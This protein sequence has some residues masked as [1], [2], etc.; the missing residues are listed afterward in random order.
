MA[1]KVIV[2][3]AS[4]NRLIR[5]HLPGWV[6]GE[7]ARGVAQPCPVLPCFVTVPFEHP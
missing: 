1:R 2:G 7:G 6:P 5:G 3:A 4:I